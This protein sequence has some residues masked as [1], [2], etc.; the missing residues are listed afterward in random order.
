MSWLTNGDDGYS[1]CGEDMAAD[2]AR[3]LYKEEI[4]KF[5]AIERFIEDGQSGKDILNKLETLVH[6]MWK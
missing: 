2:T 6:A 5:I 1:T 4:L 3:K